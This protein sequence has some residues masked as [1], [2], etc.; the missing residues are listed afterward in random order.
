MGVR[1]TENDVGVLVREVD[2]TNKVREQCCGAW[3]LGM[4]V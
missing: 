3:G 1:M 2:T 4:W